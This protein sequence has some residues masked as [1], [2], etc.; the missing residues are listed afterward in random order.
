MGQGAGEAP[1]WTLRA[2]ELLGGSTE[3]RLIDFEVVAE[4][5][6]ADSWIAP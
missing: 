4:I 5:G 6:F 3:A 2:R 1:S